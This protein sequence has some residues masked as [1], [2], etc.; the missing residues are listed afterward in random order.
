MNTFRLSFCIFTCSVSNPPSCILSWSMP[1]CDWS[2]YES[3]R[4]WFPVQK[5]N[6]S[7]F[8]SQLFLES[9][10]EFCQ[11]LHRTKMQNKLEEQLI[12]EEDLKQ[13][14]RLFCLFVLVG[15]RNHF[16]SSLL[17]LFFQ[18]G[19]Q[20]NCWRLSVIKGCANKLDCTAL[21]LSLPPFFSPLSSLFPRLISEQKLLCVPLTRWKWRDCQS[22]DLFLFKCPLVRLKCNKCAVLHSKPRLFWAIG[23]RNQ[24]V[25]AHAGLCCASAVWGALWL[26]GRAWMLWRSCWVSRLVSFVRSSD[27]LQRRQVSAAGRRGGFQG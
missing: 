18:W 20:W 21:E 15:L 19:A 3:H 6:F 5:E 16:H 24:R 25:R 2:Y 14:L 11:F 26:A 10:S 8:T 27:C 9:H 12:T 4:G 13:S 7:V 22:G 1:V 17:L 23:T